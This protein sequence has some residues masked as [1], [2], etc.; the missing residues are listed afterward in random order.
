MTNNRKGR[1]GWHQATP[2]ISK[3]NGNI[4][5]LALSVKAPVIILFIWD[6][7]LVGLSDWLIERGEMHDE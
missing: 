7:L 3:I 2:N 1:T 4:T 5:R 6:C